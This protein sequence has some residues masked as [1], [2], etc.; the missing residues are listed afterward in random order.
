VPIDEQ[1][2]HLFERHVADQFFDVDAAIAQRATGPVRL[3]DL[4]GEGD[5][6]LE[7]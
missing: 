7:A 4:G 3:G 6:A 2:P 5:Y 1:P